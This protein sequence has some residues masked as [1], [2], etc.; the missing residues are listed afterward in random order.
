VGRILLLL[1]TST[2]ELPTGSLAIA[3]LTVDGVLDPSFATGGV[4]S[5]IFPTEPDAWLC[6]FAVQPG[7]GLLLGG[8]TH[9]PQEDPFPFLMRLDA[10]GQHDAS[11]GK[12]GIVR[13]EPAGGGGM[14]CGLASQPDG[15]IVAVGW[16]TRLV[17][18]PGCPEGPCATLMRSAAWRFD[19]GGTLDPTFADDGR[20]AFQLELGKEER[21]GPALLQV[22][23]QQDGKLLTIGYNVP[24]DN[25]AY[26]VIRL[27]SDGT[28]DPSF[29]RGDGFL[30]DHTAL[31][32]P[33]LP[34]A[35]A[36]RTDGGIVAALR[37]L[38]LALLAPAGERDPMFGEGGALVVGSGSG[39]K[40]IIDD[41]DRIL[42]VASERGDETY[43][44][45]RFT[46][47]GIPDASFGESG[48]VTTPF[49]V[50]A[51]SESLSGIPLLALQPGGK[52]VAASFT[53]RDE[54][55]VPTLARYLG[56][57]DA[58]RGDP[59]TRDQ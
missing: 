57:L 8:D 30:L 1:E 28:L 14:V 4:Q 33:A 17:G 31:E 9:A 45:R 39:G 41:Q 38:E 47:I 37:D 34:P 7:G 32:D 52:V 55:I 11:F 2:S 10:S 40:F 42:I 51:G 29:G 13:P 54:R 49:R 6:T 48:R 3:R 43:S 53:L 46:P 25:L 36:L 16:T 15:K 44:L 56:E 59:A 21:Y 23:V 19:A 24:F 5:D 18:G 58:K 12:S 26:W 20:V 22:I 27:A 35:I 50:D